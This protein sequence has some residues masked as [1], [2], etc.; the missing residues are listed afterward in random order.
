MKAVTGILAIL[1]V[2]GDATKTVYLKRP[3][4]TRPDFA[5]TSVHYEIAELV[6]GAECVLD[7][8][9]CVAGGGWWALG[10]GK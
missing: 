3:F 2:D 6:G 8:G 4:R 1:Q 5:A 10:S 9:S 7:S